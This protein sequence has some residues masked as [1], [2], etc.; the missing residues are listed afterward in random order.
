MKY[1]ISVP[2]KRDLTVTGQLIAIRVLITSFEVEYQMIGEIANL[3]D[4][5]CFVFPISYLNKFFEINSSNE[6][7]VER[8][9]FQ[10]SVINTFKCQL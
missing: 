4:T 1:V 9:Q 3:L 8:S 2:T 7:M 10:Q 5:Q 6:R